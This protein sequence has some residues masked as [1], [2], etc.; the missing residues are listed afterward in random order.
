M[1]RKIVCTIIDEHKDEIDPIFDD[2]MENNISPKTAMKFA[3]YKSNA[4][5]KTL[6][7]LY[8]QNVIDIYE[9]CRQPIFKSIMKKA[10]EL[11]DDG[12]S[13]REAIASAVSYRKYALY[14]LMYSQFQE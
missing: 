2:N 1:F 8:T 14:D 11:M 5:K 12:F 3:L 9:E 10:Q 13:V 6:R 7:R 4:V